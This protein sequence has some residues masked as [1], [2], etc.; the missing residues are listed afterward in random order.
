[1]L[2]R[3]SGT[4]RWPFH[5]NEAVN[6]QNQL[7]YLRSIRKIH[8]FIIVNT[9][10]MKL[11]INEQVFPKCSTFIQWCKPLSS[12]NNFRK[13][14]SDRHVYPLKCWFFSP[15]HHQWPTPR[16]FKI[17]ILSTLR[18]R[19]RVDLNYDLRNTGEPHLVLQR[20]LIFLS[21]DH[22]CNILISVFKLKKKFIH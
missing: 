6:P 20:A 9:S 14:F 12:L 18:S 11:D 4:L 7:K 8:Q 3:W 10:S 21:G 17:L 1:V 13:N 19:R 5:E 15:H 22:D 16:L 2:R